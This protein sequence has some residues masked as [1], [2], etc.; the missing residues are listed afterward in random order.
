MK[1][2]LSFCFFIT[3]Y[4]YEIESTLIK[5][6]VIKFIC[7]LGGGKGKVTKN[8]VLRGLS[9]LLIKNTVDSAIKKFQISEEQLLEIAEFYSIKV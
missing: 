3:G 7:E 5:N 1:S 4:F 9:K 2:L 8:F 6:E